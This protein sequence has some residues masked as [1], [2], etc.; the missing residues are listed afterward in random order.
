MIVLLCFSL[1]PQPA[2]LRRWSAAARRLAQLTRLRPPEDECVIDPPCAP[3]GD[4][5]FLRH[6]ESEW[7]AANR[8]T[9]WVDVPLT[10]RGEAEALDAA[11]QLAAAGVCV[12]VCYT[13]TLKRTIKTAWL[14]LEA[15]DSFNTPVERRWRLNER[16]YGA[17]TGLNKDETR[18]FLGESGFEELRRVPPPLERGSCYDPARSKG[19]E[20]A[21]AA[22]VPRAESFEDTTARVLPCWR[23]EIL[24]AAQ[25]GKTVLVVSSKNALRS[26]I[27]GISGLPLED[28]V[29]LDVPNGAPLIFRP[30][31]R[32]LTLLGSG[33]PLASEVVPAP[34][35]V[36]E[37]GGGG[38]TASRRRG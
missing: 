2:G 10:Q 1:V 18:R 23:D 20:A 12:D 27:A 34:L 3:S 7:N 24:P 36:D 8:F 6:G 13:S 38:G 25:A 17:L 9:G 4:I 33:E 30:E 15:L 35:A 29:H 26:L 31:D 19:G 22:E 5:I 32:S 11:A 28:A 21:A 37:G 16:M 14:V